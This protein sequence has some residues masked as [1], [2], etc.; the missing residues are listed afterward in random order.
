MKTVLEVGGAVIDASTV[1]PQPLHFVIENGSIQSYALGR[2]ESQANQEPV[3]I[4]RKGNRIAMPGLVN[5]HGH[6]AM[7]LLRGAGD[8]LPL[9]TWLNERIFPLEDK[10]TEEAIYWGTQLAAW[11]ML[12]SGTT[13]YTDMYMMMH[14]A[15]EAVAESGI[16]AVLSVG[17]VGFDETSRN[18]G[19]QRS[20]AFHQAWHN[21]ASGRITVTLGPHAPYTCPPD[22]LHELARLADE[23]AIPA[24]I[25]LSETSVEVD[26]ALRDHGQS[27]IA[28]AQQVG[29]LDVPVLAAHC[30]HVTDADLEIMAQYGVHVAHNPQS[31][32]KLGSGIAPLPKMLERGLV[33]GLGTDGAASNNNLDMFEE[34]RLAATLH[35]GVAQDAEVVPASVAF[36]LAT[37]KGAKACFLGDQHGTLQVGAKADIVLLDASSP[38]MLPQHNM[39]SDVVYACGADDVRD[40]FVDGRQV[41][42][43]G[44]P[45]TIDVERVQS[46]VLRIKEQFRA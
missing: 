13:T 17:V 30:V 7:T 37:A 38:H 24:Q 9:M 33:V 1:I 12:C 10:L 45:L 36:D 32:L 31:N 39:L 25:H 44:V 22:Y 35:K 16:R 15:A 4:I 41:V 19:I 42:S 40:V 20:R 3:E 14:H 46:E 34:M 43:D 28:L 18:N 27:P 23:L 29:L 5:T 26:N 6:A 11:E 8:D 21:Q 2:Y